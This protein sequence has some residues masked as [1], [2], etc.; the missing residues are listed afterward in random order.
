MANNLKKTRF[1][2]RKKHVRKVIFGTAVRPRLSVS[3]SIRNIHAQIIDDEKMVTLAAC[4]SLSKD[5]AAKAG[6]KKK[7]QVAAMV[8]EALAKIAREKGIE[9]VS[10]D[11]NGNL[12]H[13]RVKSLAD[14]ARKA[15]LKF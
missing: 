4:S 1:L 13:G 9:T 15:G 5:V 2:R 12:Y 8:G 11:R 3:K 14:A 7:I 10:F 6:D